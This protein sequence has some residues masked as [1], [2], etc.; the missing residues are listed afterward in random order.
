MNII[1]KTTKTISFY[2][3]FVDSSASEISPTEVK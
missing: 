2:G 1:V 3:Q